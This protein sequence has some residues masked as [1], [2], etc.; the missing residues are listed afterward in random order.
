M[1]LDPP[2]EL[3]TADAGVEKQSM[4]NYARRRL[5][6]VTEDPGSIPGGS[7]LPGDQPA[8]APA[9]RWR[10]KKFIRRDKGS[11]DPVLAVA[12]I[13]VVLA[14]VVFGVIAFT[15]VKWSDLTPKT[16]HYAKVCVSA[17]SH[18]RVADTDCKA[19]SARDAD[20]AAD[21]FIWYYFISG[22]QVPGIGST[23]TGGTR[24]ISSGS[25][26]TSGIPA[27]G[28][29]VSKAGQVGTSDDEEE[30][31]SSTYTSPDDE[32]EQQGTSVQQQQQDEEEEQ[33]SS[34]DEDEEESVSSSSDD[35]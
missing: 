26:V 21:G 18:E 6:S 24:S 33:Q 2:A 22:S 16:D 17:T 7:T 31:N 14:L 20:A 13:T 10:M 28:G 5:R 12:A 11:S 34:T 1:R 32:E 8:T 29:T 25:S 9:H 23:V 27:M 19:A 15:H 35:E 3:F 30:E 4:V